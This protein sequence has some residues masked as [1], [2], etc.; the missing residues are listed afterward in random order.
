MKR[1]YGH[2]VIKFEIFEKNKNNFFIKQNISFLFKTKIYIFLFL[3]KYFFQIPKN[4]IADT[5][6]FKQKPQR[7]ADCQGEFQMLNI[8]WNE[9]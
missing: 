7:F 3:E 2:H 1:E 6:K 9:N 5:K 4:T 8:P